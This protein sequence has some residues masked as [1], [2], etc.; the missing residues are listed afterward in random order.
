MAS[1]KQRAKDFANQKIQQA[2]DFNFGQHDPK[3]H[4]GDGAPHISRQEINSMKS[5][6]ASKDRNNLKENLAV[7]QKQKE[8]GAAFSDK[9]QKILTRMEDRMENRLSRRAEAKEKAQAAQKQPP[10]D[11]VQDTNTPAVEPDQ[12]ATTLPYNEANQEVEITNTQE[13]N[14]NQD[15]DISN[16]ISGNN[17]YVVNQQDNSVRQYGGDNRSFVYNSAG[18]GG[19]ETPGTMATLAGFYD[20][21][22][23]PAAQ[24][25]FHDLHTDLNRQA[26]KKYL[27]SSYI[28]QGAIH[29]AGMNS[30]IDP[31]KLRAATHARSQAARDRAQMMDEQLFGN[32]EFQ[33]DWTPNKIVSEKEDP[34]IMGQAEDI[35]DGL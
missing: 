7:L 23:S 26:Q 21:D 1:R 12:Q 15:N 2:K 34:D 14:V 8:Q 24:A 19:V 31:A 13:Q 28:A 11:Q 29:R 35:M 20:V 17:N 5:Q 27:D 4:S 10:A 33:L 25:K 32:K 3:T 22:D 16:N 18:G 30:Y 9:S 6:T